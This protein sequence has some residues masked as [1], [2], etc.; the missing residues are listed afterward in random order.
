MGNNAYGQCGRR[1][2]EDEVYR[3]VL[4]HFAHTNTA[5][6]YFNIILLYFTLYTKLRGF[7][8]TGKHFQSGEC[9]ILKENLTFKTQ[10]IKQ[11]INKPQSKVIINGNIEIQNTGKIL[12]K[13]VTG[14]PSAFIK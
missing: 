6:K 14:H 7:H 4:K 13:V 1:I 11:T 2:V 10:D 9:S 8:V 12:A 3:F 5:C